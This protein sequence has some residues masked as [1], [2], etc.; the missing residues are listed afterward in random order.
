[1]RDSNW[2]RK[3][4]SDRSD[5]ENPT[6]AE[7]G[8]PPSAESADIPIRVGSPFAVDPI[9]PGA[10][11]PGVK[12]PD[13]TKPIEPFLDVGPLRYTAMGA[14]AASVMV[15]AFAA[16]AAWWFPSG[17]ALIAALGCVLSICGLYSTYQITSAGLLAIHLCLFVL[18]YGRSLG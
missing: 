5:T 18:C 3:W 6:P 7:P 9:T 4:T 15:L 8:N 1:M 14:V 16:A 10:I 2:F 13:V 12:K 11:S 17:G